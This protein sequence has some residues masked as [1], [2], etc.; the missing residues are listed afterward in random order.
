MLGVFRGYFG[1][2]RTALNYHL[3]CPSFVPFISK[4]PT[5]IVEGVKSFFKKKHG[6]E[7]KYGNAAPCGCRKR[8]ALEQRNVGVRRHATRCHRPQVDPRRGS[9]DVQDAQVIHQQIS[10]FASKLVIM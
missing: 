3:N 5:E 8:A 6:I 10:L 7:L 9:G 1:T 2:S 4:L